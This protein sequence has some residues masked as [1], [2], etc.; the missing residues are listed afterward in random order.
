M[1]DRG[2]TEAEVAFDRLFGGYFDRLRRFA[3]RYLRSWDEAEDTVHDVFVRLWS[4][5]DRMSTIDNIDAYLYTATRNRALG[6][7]KHLAIERQWR[8][9]AESQSVVHEEV[10]AAQHGLEQAELA[11][12]IQRALDTLTERQRDAM[13]LVWRGKSYNEIAGVLQI[14]PKTVSVHLSRAYDALRRVLPPL[15]E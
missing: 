4:T 5:W 2:P 8:A 12:A 10:P 15:L 9:R 13:L 3:Y 6:R 1:G 7:L 11:G 14:S